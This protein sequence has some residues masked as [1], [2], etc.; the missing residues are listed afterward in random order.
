MI[1]VSDTPATAPATNCQWKGIGTENKASNM[2]VH[3]RKILDRKVK[4]FTGIVGAPLP[5]LPLPLPL[6]LLLG[7]LLL[8]PLVLVLILT[9]YYVA[10]RTTGLT[11][12]GPLL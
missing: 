3:M 4:P 2:S 9:L 12:D 1:T 10:S 8:L 11:E 7:E 6:P 5:R